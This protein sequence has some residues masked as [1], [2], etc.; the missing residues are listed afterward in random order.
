MWVDCKLQDVAIVQQSYIASLKEF[1]DLLLTSNP[2]PLNAMVF[3]VDAE[4]HYTSINAL[5]ALQG[6]GAYLRIN[7]TLFSSV[8]VNALM[9]GLRLVM[10]YNVFTFGDTFWIQLSETAMGTLSVYNYVTLYFAIHEDHILP[11]HPNIAC[12]KEY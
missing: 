1:K 3:T 7:E 11:T 5:Q 4:L 12:Y 10:T 2:F 9:T 8:T 6:I